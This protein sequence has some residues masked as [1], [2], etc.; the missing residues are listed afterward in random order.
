[1]DFWAVTWHYYYVKKEQ[2]IEDFLDCVQKVREGKLDPIIGKY[3]PLSDA[4]PVN[5][6]LV[7]GVGVQGKLLFVVDKKLATGKL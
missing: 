1:M 2:F 5:E 6:M 3:F 7:S 4:I